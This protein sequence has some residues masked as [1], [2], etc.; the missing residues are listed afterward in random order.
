MDLLRSRFRKGYL[1]RG[2]TYSGLLHFRMETG[3]MG[4]MNTLRGLRVLRQYDPGLCEQLLRQP[5]TL[6]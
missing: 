5:L 2:S 6:P 3:R 1:P 4:A